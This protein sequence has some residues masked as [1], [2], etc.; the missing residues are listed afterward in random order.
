MSRRLPNAARLPR[1]VYSGWACVW[2]GASL[3]L[4]GAPA[5]R[6]RGQIGAFCLDVDVYQCLP[7]RDCPAATKP[8]PATEG[9]RR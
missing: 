1:A 5:G 7:G 6:A 4:G 3:S 8:A 2:C 9:S